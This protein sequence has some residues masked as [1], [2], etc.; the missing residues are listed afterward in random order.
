MGVWGFRG[1][2]VWG[3][4]GLGVWG[5]GGLRF[6]GIGLSSFGGVCRGHVYRLKAIVVPSGAI[7]VHGASCW[8]VVL[9]PEP[10]LSCLF[11]VQDYLE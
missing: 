9:N 4:R 6:R 3:F 5:F 1:L 2:G 10:S 8:V 7:A 11:G